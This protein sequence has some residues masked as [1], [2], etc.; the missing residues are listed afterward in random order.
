MC[1]TDMDGRCEITDTTDRDE[2]QRLVTAMDD[3]YDMT[4]ASDTKK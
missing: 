3:R 4:D 2:L 1:M